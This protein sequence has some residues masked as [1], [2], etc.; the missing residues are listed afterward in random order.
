MSK[1]NRIEHA[2]EDKRGKIKSFVELTGR[3]S[4]K[5]ISNMIVEEDSGFLSSGTVIRNR[6]NDAKI[7]RPLES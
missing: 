1:R 5:V 6:K 4:T 3:N 2:D 7:T